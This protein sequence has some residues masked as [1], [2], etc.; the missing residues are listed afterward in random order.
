MGDED[1]KARTMEGL[2]SAKGF[3][4]TSLAQALTLKNVPELRFV[5]DRGLEHAARIDRILAELKSSEPS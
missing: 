4:R 1:E 2:H 3:L 5:L